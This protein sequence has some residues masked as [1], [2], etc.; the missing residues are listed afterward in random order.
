[1]K[2]GINRKHEFKFCSSNDEITLWLAEIGLYNRMDYM[3][4]Y[5]AFRLRYIDSWNVLASPLLPI[6]AFVMSFLLFL[7]VVL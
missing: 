2:Y 4:G 6:A 1:M 3:L 7:W 5:Y